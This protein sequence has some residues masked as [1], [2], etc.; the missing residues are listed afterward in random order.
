MARPNLNNDP[1][2]LKRKTEGDEFIEIQKDGKTRSIKYIKI[3]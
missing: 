1:E 2:L 3:T